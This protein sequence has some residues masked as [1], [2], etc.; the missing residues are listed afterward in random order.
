LPAD[1]DAWMIGSQKNLLSVILLHEGQFEAAR[2]V[3]DAGPP[4]LLQGQPLLAG[5]QGIL[6]GH[7]LAGLSHA[8]EGHIAQAEQIYREVLKT[9]AGVDA[10]CRDAV[11]LATALLGEVL[12]ERG[13]AAAAIALLEPQLDLLERFSLPDTVL[14]GLLTLARSHRLLGHHLECQSC[15]ERLDD[16]AQAHGLDRLR[17]ASLMEQTLGLMRTLQFAQADRL[18]ERLDALAARHAQR[19]GSLAEVQHIAT[20]AHIRRALAHGEFSHAAALLTRFTAQCE[21]RGNWQRVARLKL[22]HAVTTRASSQSDRAGAGALEA[23]RLGHRLGLVRSLLDAHPE[24]AQIVQT[25]QAQGLDPVL[26]FYADRL[27][28]AHSRIGA[29]SEAEALPG[30]PAPGLAEALTQREA[31]VLQQLLQALPNKKIARVLGLSI[32]TV[33]WHLRNV[34]RK[35]D[36]AGRD[37]A[38]TRARDLG[39]A[40]APATPPAERAHDSSGVAAERAHDSSGAAP[41]SLR[42]GMQGAVRRQ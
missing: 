20:G 28:A 10:D 36:V 35:L 27:L 37:D 7:C 13:E 26:H 25:V 31:D 34:Y 6:A 22:L 39:L 16:H 29:R 12:Y 33:K 21:A 19:G 5:T 9:A 1:A 8:Q 32:E 24:A 30:P 40:N 14:R 3:Q 4:R 15:L 42:D 23:L 38:V 2:Q 11:F 17:A 18:I 41:V